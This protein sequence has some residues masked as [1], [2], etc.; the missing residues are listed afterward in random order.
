MREGFGTAGV[1]ASVRF[2]ARVSP[3]VLLQVRELCEFPLAD[4][5]P[6]RKEENHTFSSSSE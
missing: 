4:F 3:N 5:A 2:I 6:E 1:S